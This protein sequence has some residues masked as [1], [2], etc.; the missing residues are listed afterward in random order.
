[1]EYKGV[2]RSSSLLAVSGGAGLK[3]ALFFYLVFRENLMHVEPARAAPL[4]LVYPTEHDFI[5]A[6][7][8]DFRG[9]IVIPQGR[10]VK[11]IL[12]AHISSLFENVLNRGDSVKLV[13][14]EPVREAV[15]YAPPADRYFAYGSHCRGL[16]VFLYPF[17]SDF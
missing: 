9:E 6:R 5:P 2:E 11:I 8:T 16:E 1:M 17:L 10:P 7:E 15:L 14:P 4:G 13:L 3:R 12:V